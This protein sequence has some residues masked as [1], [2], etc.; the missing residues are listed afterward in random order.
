MLAVE[1]RLPLQAS[2][3]AVWAIVGDV[4]RIDWVPVITHCALQG[5]VRTMTMSGVGEVQERILRRDP[6]AMLLE[7]GL[8]NN[9][10]VTVHRARLQ[11]LPHA[12]GCELEW[13]TQIE[14]DA[15]EPLIAA[16]MDSALQAL[17]AV[18]AKAQPA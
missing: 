10:R 17:Q 9:P 14:P 4:T 1:R 7:Y 13:V 5:D 6:I 2:A 18:L 16:G 3:T 11:V 8:I 15:L 12:G